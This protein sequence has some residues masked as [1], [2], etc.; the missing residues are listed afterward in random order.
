MLASMLAPHMKSHWITAR[1]MYD[2]IAKLGPDTNPL[3]KVT[4]VVSSYAEQAFDTYAKPLNAAVAGAQKDKV[5]ALVSQDLWNAFVYKADAL[6][7]F[8]SG[9]TV[10]GYLIRE[11]REIGVGNSYSL[12]K[13]S[14]QELAMD[15]LT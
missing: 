13:S 10:D 12:T 7:T 1:Y 15:F 9:R 4:A 11:S 6:F 8:D 2:L 14:G 5:V 3:S